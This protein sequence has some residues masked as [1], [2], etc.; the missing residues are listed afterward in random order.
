MFD[1]TNICLI[2][3]FLCFSAYVIN[4]VIKKEKSYL[5]NPNSYRKNHQ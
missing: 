1:M 2:L 5:K 4:S 3:Y